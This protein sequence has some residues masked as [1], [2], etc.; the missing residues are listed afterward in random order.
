MY[1]ANELKILNQ[2]FELEPIKE[3]F[4]DILYKVIAE[5]FKDKN[6]FSADDFTF[7]T[8]DEHI[9]NTDCNN[10][11]FTCIYIDINQPNN[12]K[13]DTKKSKKINSSKKRKSYE[14]PNLFLSLSDIKKGIYEN[15]IKH[16]DNNNIIWMDKYSICIKST[17]LWD[18]NIKINYYF[19]ITPAFTYYNDNN[20]RGIVYY[21]NNDI[22][23]EY[24]E[25]FYK[26]FNIKNE[27]T[28]DMFRQ[29]V[30]IFK[31]IILL[32]EKTIETIPSEIIE[33][34]LYNVPNNMLKSD[35]K[36]SLINIINFIRNNPL[37]QF[38]TIDEQDYAFASVYRGMSGIYSKHIL[39]II[40]RYLS[41]S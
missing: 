13:Y 26:N 28:K 25:S 33:T 15:C 38:K 37:S 40:E 18:N 16:F 19:K 17:V 27:L 32:E 22:Q 8:L 34:L 2:P 41:R 24:P 4:M 31:N 7:Y 10:D 30:V 14:I 1:I 12:Y 39:K 11:I 9:L 36:A 5:F 20:V 21:N 6:M 23:I 29:L 3:S 35:D